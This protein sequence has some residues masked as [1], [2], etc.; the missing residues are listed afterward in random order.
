MKRVLALA[1]FAVIVAMWVRPDAA[2]ARSQTVLFRIVSV[3]AAATEAERTSI[4]SVQEAEIAFNVRSRAAL[5][6]ERLSIPLMDGKT[7]EARRVELETRGAEDLTWRGKIGGGDVVLTFKNGYVAGAIYA[8]NDV[9]EVVPKGDKQILVKLNHSLF[10]EC[11]GEVVSNEKIP[12]AAESALGQSADSGDRVDVLVVYTTATKNILGGD[13]QAQAHAQAAID[14]ANTAYLNS[15]I[16]MRVRMVHSQEFVY[17]ETSSASTD[18]SNLRNNAGIQALRETHK[19]DLVAEISEAAGVCGIGY[20]M[21]SLPGNANNGFTVTNRT[22]AVGN[23]TLGHEMGHNMGSHHN[24]ENGGTATFPFSYGHY[25]SGQFRTVMSYVDPCSGGC[26]RRP[27][28]SNPA[29]EYLGFATGT[30]G[31]RDNARSINNTADAIA[32]YRYSGSS[33]TLTSFNGPEML[34]RYVMSAQRPVAWSSN[35]IT[36]G[37]RIELSRDEGSSWETLIADTADDSTQNVTVTGRMTKRARI[38][39]TSVNSPWVTDSS[40]ANIT[41]R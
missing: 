5:D 23:V 3:P 21:G 30:D 11:G 26:P 24:P 10:P 31:A 1:V 27:Y 38:R 2:E 33:L 40:T 34:P 14:M 22:C 20:L 36:G 32:N 29:I 25:V 8:G 6:V 35:G 39:V 37:I 19:A 16:R 7:H 4:A 18:L 13:A 41:L 12:P 17:T 9:Y 15:R 28:F